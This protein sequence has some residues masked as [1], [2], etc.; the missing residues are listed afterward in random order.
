MVKYLLDPF[1]LFWLLLAG[2]LC[3]YYFRKKRLFRGLAVTLS[4]W[5]LVIS[6]PL[7]PTLVLDSL[8]SRYEPVTAG[9]LPDSSAAYH[10]LVLGGGHG[11]DSRLPANDLLS[12][13]ALGRLGEGIRLWRQLP[14]SKLVL[15]GFSGGGSTTQ[16]EMLQ[17]AA[18]LLGVDSSSTILQTEPGSTYEEAEVYAEKYGSSHPVILVTSAA[19][20]PRALRMFRSFG[21]EPIPSP[22]NYRLLGAN[23]SQWIGWPA[24]VH[25]EHL[26][27]GIYEYAGLWWA[28][29][30]YG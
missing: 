18:V 13:T 19:H 29:V 11:F 8:E 24:M 3:A 10:I 15:S 16:A 2:L 28:A 27:V 20:M 21:I 9:E 22:T 7:V 26:R 1:N 12:H 23:R 14:N 30:R 17:Q 4:V 6:T 5:F 25:I